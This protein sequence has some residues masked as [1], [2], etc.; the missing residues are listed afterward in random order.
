MWELEAD[1]GTPNT[2][3]SEILTQDLAKFVLW[4]L[5]P[6]QKEDHA[7]CANDLIQTATNESD[8][9]KK[10]INGD[11]SW[12]YGR[13]VKL[14]FTGGHISLMVAFKGPNVILGLYKC[15]FFLTRGKELGAAAR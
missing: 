13:V 9:L 2:T 4:I 11:E 6:E 14:I 15:N 7:A 12:V 3:A 1:L 10:S 5:L 8:F